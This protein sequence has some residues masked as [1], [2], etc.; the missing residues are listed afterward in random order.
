M[1]VHLFDMATE[2]EIGLLSDEQF[3]FLQQH[4]EAEG[5]DDDDYYINRE[6][7][8]LFQEQGGD[9]AVVGM[10]RTAMGARADID[11]RWQRDEP[12]QPAG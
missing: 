9:P 1:S 4:L 5:P 3:Q 6:T 10:L 8:D 7:L 12:E 2:Q 11:V